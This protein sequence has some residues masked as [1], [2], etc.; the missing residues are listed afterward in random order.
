MREIAHDPAW[1][2]WLDGDEPALKAQA[3]VGRV[4]TYLAGINMHSL[5]FLLE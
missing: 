3:L 2:G 4:L 1:K 5:H